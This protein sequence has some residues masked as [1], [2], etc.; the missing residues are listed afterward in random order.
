METYTIM[1]KIGGEWKLL[2]IMSP[3]ARRLPS[4]LNFTLDGAAST[5]FLRRNADNMAAA[6]RANGLECLICIN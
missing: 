4:G 2:D 3:E 1:V 5:R 6:L